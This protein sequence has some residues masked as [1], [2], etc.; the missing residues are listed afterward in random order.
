MAERNGA[1]YRVIQAALSFNFVRLLG[2]VVLSALPDMYRPI[3]AH[4]VGHVW[5]GALKP[6]MTN[7][8]QYRVTAQQAREMAGISEF[9]LNTR[10][11][12]MADIAD[13]SNNRTATENFIQTMSSVASTASG[14]T[15]WNDFFKGIATQVTT[16]RLRKLSDGAADEVFRK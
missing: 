8:K 4:G 7:V 16:S 15:I 12:S 2:Q 11:M 6:M 5:A 13:P 3:M 14:M 10:L 9:A 1:P